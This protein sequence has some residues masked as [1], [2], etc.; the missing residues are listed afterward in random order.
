M[1]IQV[2]YRCFVCRDMRLITP[3]RHASEYRCHTGVFVCRDM[4][5]STNLVP[6]AAHVVHSRGAVRVCRYVPMFGDTDY[7]LTRRYVA[8]SFEDQLGALAD[9]QRAGK[10]RQWGLSNETPWG[11]TKWSHTACAGGLPPPVSLQ[12]AYSLLCRTF[13]AG[14]AEACAEEHVPLLA[15]SP[16]AMGLLTGKYTA[17][18]DGWRGPPGSRLMRY[19]GRYAEAESRCALDRRFAAVGHLAGAPWGRH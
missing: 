11:L 7:D 8:A 4:R 1:Y 17:M 13:D 16:L 2:S 19:K 6:L 5:L 14:L 10:I 18:P 15:Y 9:A 3:V 12:N